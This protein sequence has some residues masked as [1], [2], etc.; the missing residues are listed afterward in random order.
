MPLEIRELI[1]KATVNDSKEKDA[2]N[3]APGSQE[4]KDAQKAM[5][6][7]CIDDIMDILNSQKER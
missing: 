1:I 2:A 5:L 7:Q 3:S 6:Q 4:S